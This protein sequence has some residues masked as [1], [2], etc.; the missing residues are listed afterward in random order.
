[1]CEFRQSIGPLIPTA[2]YTIL[3]SLA[4]SVSCYMAVAIFV[5][6]FVFPQTLNHLCMDMISAQ[7]GRVKALVDIQREVLDADPTD[8]APGTKLMES[9]GVQRTQLIVGQRQRK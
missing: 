8:L 3:K 6:I 5:T 7:L 1:M 4:I 9:V 2:D